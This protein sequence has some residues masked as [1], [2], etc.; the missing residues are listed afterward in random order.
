MTENVAI[1]LGSNIG[2]APAQIRAAAAEMGAFL[3]DITL[4]PLYASTP[5]Y[6]ADQPDFVNSVLTAKT[7]LNPMELLKKLKEMEVHL[8]RQS[9][10]RNGPR[11]IDLDIVL[12]GTQ[13]IDEPDLTIPHPR[14]SE[15][16]F[17]LVPLAEV[18]PDWLHPVLGL[19]VDSMA[20]L[21]PYEAR[22]LHVLG[23]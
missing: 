23:E 6:Y 13:I 21:L 14:M 2:D 7:S 17:V 15:R 5:M 8:G 9:T 4:A 10:F 19:R 12:Y 3:T 22:D 11:V 20:K 18:A 1:A 16:P